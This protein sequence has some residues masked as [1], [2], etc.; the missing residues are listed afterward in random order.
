MCEVLSAVAW[1][2]ALHL[3][4]VVPVTIFYLII[5]TLQISK[6]L[7]TMNCF[8]FYSQIIVGAFTYDELV[9]NNVYMKAPPFLQTFFD[10]LITLTI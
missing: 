1:L 6:Q 9:I 8:V 4:P 3:F 10:I 2:V 5:F 7:A